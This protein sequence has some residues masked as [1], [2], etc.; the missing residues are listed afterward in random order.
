MSLKD[1][2]LKHSWSPF[3]SKKSYPIYYGYSDGS[4]APVRSNFVNVTDKSVVTAVYNRLSVDAASMNFMHAKLDDNGRYIKDIK[5]NLN[6]CLTEQANIDQTGRAFM[7]DAISTLLYDGCAALVPVETKI[8]PELY[9]SYDI[10]SLRVGKVVQW[11][12]QHV[13]VR[14]YNE[15]TGKREDIQLSKKMVALPINPFYDIMNEPNSTLKR[16]NRKISLLDYVDEQSRYGK[17]DLIVQL[18]YSIKTAARQKEANDRR[19]EI[20]NQLAGSKYGIAYIDATEKITQ[21]NR[22]IENT[23]ADEVTTLTK[24]LFSQLGITEEILNGTAS[25][26]VMANYYS[27]TI[28]PIVDVIADSMNIKFLTKTARTQHQSIIYFRDPFK[29]VPVS[30]VADMADKFTR[31]EILSSNEFRGIIGRKPSD[32]P[33]ADK[34]L[35]KNINHGNE[36]LGME[37][38]DQNTTDEKES[39]NNNYQKEIEDFISRIKN[40]KK[41]E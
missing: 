13:V 11:Y 18:P 34:L 31:N 15:K 30:K 21:L 28:E 24:M 7:Q 38:K 40:K 6:Y 37:N 35:N 22:P 14:V 1:R 23:L 16:L 20:E 17:L 8:N 25:E 26:D 32:D 19:K 36:E 39:S 41:E 27:R 12:P 29:L 10:F 33:K 9:G 4:V 5:S 3:N 2:F